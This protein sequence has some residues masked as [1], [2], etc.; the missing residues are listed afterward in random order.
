MKKLSCKT[1]GLLAAIVLTSNAVDARFIEHKE[2]HLGPT[3]LFGVTSP[4]NIVITKVQK[5]SP[6]DGKIKVGDVIVGAGGVAFK[7]STR[8]QL[9]D[10]IDQ[11]ETK[12][13]KGVL[14]L[15]LKGGKKVDLQLKVLGSYSDTAPRDCLKTDAIITQTGDYL[16][17][18][19]KFGRGNMNI[20]L[21]GLL[22]TGE[23]KYIDVVK[24]AIHNAKWAKPDIELSLQGTYKAWKWGYTSLLLCEY[25]LLTGDK[26]VLPAIRAYSVA[27]ARGRDAAGLWGHRMADP[28]INRGQLHGRLHGYGVMNQSSLPLFISLQLAGKCG[29]RDGEVQDGVK[30]THAFYNSFIGRGTLPYGVHDP[31]SK[32]YNNNGMSGSAAVALSLYGNKRGAAF[33]SRMSAAA[34]NIMETGHTGHF[35]N[36]LWTGLGAN[37][38]GPET[39]AAFFKKTRWLHTL[40]RMWDG[41]FTYDGCAYPKGSFKYGGGMSSAGSHLLNYCLARRKLYMTGRGADESIWLKG[42]EVDDTIA[43][44]TMDFKTK[45]DAELLA[46]FAH[47]MPPVRVNAIWTL[48]SRKHK[49]VD[50]IRKMV[51]DGTY[52]Q[53][54]SACGYFGYKCPPE[55]AAPSMA[56][57]ASVMRDTK[58][59]SR[60]RG[61]AAWALCWFGKDAHK[62]YNDMLK[63]IAADESDDPFAALDETVGRSLNILCPDPYKAGLVTDKKLFY[64]AV[65]KLLDHKRQSARGSGMAMILNM[66]LEDFHIVADK[67]MHI[68]EDKDLTYHSYHNPMTAMGKG[69]IVLANLNIDGGIDAA[70]KIMNAEAGKWGFKVRMMMNVLPKYGANAKPALAKLKADPRWKNIEKGRFGGAWRAMVN[71]IESSTGTRKMISPDEA[72]NAG[73]KRK[74]ENR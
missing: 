46:L 34:H 23:Q 73:R 4:T 7:D 10:A 50:S 41:N 19:K 49:L 39:M 72:K 5:G 44:A 45:S 16:V 40:N 13:A 28:G 69:L 67:V 6:A 61:T 27:I 64:A 43:L 51:K 33:F 26:Y 14:T 17:K 1:I 8:R 15:R 62:Y 68:V 71:A 35:F 25:Y 55:T 63:V 59:S 70:F 24:D 60:V 36:Q 22:A 56:D 53:K 11:A 54:L 38:A 74:T 66:P 12:K 20:G 2:H 3:G 57:L 21:L 9:A 37:L 65:G 48:R 31:Y 58:K 47:P 32:S 29:V 42:K 30:Q 52:E 18:S